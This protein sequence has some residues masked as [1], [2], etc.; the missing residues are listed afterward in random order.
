MASIA[1]FVPTPDE[2]IK[3]TSFVLK[4]HAGIV[5]MLNEQKK[6]ESGESTAG[7]DTVD[8]EPSADTA[9]EEGV[10]G[11]GATKSKKGKEKS[12]LPVVNIDDVDATALARLKLGK[13][14]QFVFIFAQVGRLAKEAYLNLAIRYSWFLIA[15]NSMT[16]IPGSC[17]FVN[18]LSH[19]SS[20]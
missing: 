17:L 13:A 7:T 18:I 14:E 6:K 5:Q 1:Q 4:K 9:L 20:D 10:E 8:A 15:M 12:Q 3:V 11:T 2:A 16:I 19:R